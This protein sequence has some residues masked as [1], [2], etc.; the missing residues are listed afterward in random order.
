MR[1]TSWSAWLLD[2]GAVA[3]ALLAPVAFADSGSS[4]LHEREAALAPKLQDNA[5]A[6]P[7]YLQ[8]SEAGDGAS[9]DV[10]AVLP[11][12]FRTIAMALSRPAQWCDMLILH[13]NVKR[14]TAAASSLALYVG[15]KH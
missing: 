3:A 9:G 14:C 12:P 6:Q 4:A 2:A 11:Q 13:L 15:G 7:L 5:F 10:Y 8:S 1:T